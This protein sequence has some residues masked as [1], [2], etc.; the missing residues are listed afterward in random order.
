MKAAFQD[1]NT[2]D[3]KTQS[4][5]EKPKR[6]RRTKAEMI[7]AAGNDTPEIDANAVQGPVKKKLCQGCHSMIEDTPENFP[8]GGDYSRFSKKYSK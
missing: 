5:V 2:P 4:E 7:A 3:I 8:D 1:E 6:K